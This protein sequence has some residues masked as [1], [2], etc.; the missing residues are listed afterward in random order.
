[1]GSILSACDSF[2]AGTRFSSGRQAFLAKRYDE[3]LAYFQKVADDSPGYMFE[4]LNFRQSVWSYLGRAQ[5]L[6]GH[7]PEARQSFERALAGNRDEYLARI[8]LALTL[9]R[10]GDGDANGVKELKNGIKGL[11]NWLDDEN[12]RNPAHTVWDPGR[13]IRSEIAKS[14]AAIAMPR[15]ERQSLIENGEWIGWAMEEEIEKVRRDQTRQAE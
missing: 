6:T 4:S 14:R 13:E 10:G 8:F 1:M 15:I 7:L 9:L 2:N 12:A 11:Q 3:A 5:Y